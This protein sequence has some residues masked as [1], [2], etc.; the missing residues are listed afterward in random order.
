MKSWPLRIPS[1]LEYR[2]T[3]NH[4]YRGRDCGS[5]STGTNGINSDPKLCKFRPRRRIRR[6]SQLISKSLRPSL[7][8]V[9]HS[10]PVSHG[11]CFA[12]RLDTRPGTDTISVTEGNGLDLLV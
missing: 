12:S 7:S 6:R 8:L 9:S 10:L 1:S 2:T 4:C 11:T 3:R 5:N